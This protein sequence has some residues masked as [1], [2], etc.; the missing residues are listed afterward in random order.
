MKN[1][2]LEELRRDPG[3]AHLCSMDVLVWLS[4]AG[5]VTTACGC[6]RQSGSDGLGLHIE[7]IWK[8]WKSC[9]IKFWQW[10]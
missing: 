6:C 4:R 9:Q 2:S 1:C 3:D 5:F 7:K 8:L 10:N